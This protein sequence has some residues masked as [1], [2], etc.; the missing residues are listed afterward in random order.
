MKWVGWFKRRQWERRMDAEFRFH[1]DSQ[2]NDYINQG[3]SRE[4]AELRA[5]RE[6][7]PLD[8]AKEECRDERP[9][10]ALD[11]FLRDI[12][13]AFRSLARS[14]GFAAAVI[15]TLGLGIGA[16]TSIY[17]VVYAVLLKPL[18]YRQENKLVS[19]EVSVP[20]LGDQFPFLPPRIQDFLRW[21]EARTAFAS[22]AASVPIQRNLTGDGEPERLNGARVSA[23]FFSVLGVPVGLGRGFVPEEEQPGRDRV[24]VIGHELWSR[25]FGSDPGLLGRSIT[26]NGINHR[27][28]GVALPALPVPNL[29]SRTREQGRLDFWIPLALSEGEL[30]NRGN[31]NYGVLARLGPGA[32]PEVGRLQLEGMLRDGLRKDLPEARIEAFI[33][34]TPVREIYVGNVR[35]RL[36]L[37]LGASGTLLLIACANVANLFLARA[38]NRAGELA[39]RIALGA[40]RGRIVRQMLTESTLLAVLGGFLGIMIAL[41]GV[42]VLLAYGPGDLPALMAGTGVNWNVLCFALAVSLLT[43]AACGVFPALR[44]CRAQAG[45]T[46]RETA[47]GS[48][49]GGGAARFRRLLIGTEMAL[50]TVLL[51][52]AGLF[53]QSFVKVITTDRGYEVDGVL[54]VELPL[55][56]PGY[57]SLD[58]RIAFYREL[59]ERV[60]SIPGIV[61]AGAI[62]D[63][64][65][66]QET[67]TTTIFRKDDTNAA[68]VV[69][70]RPVAGVRC[71][72]PGYFAA[73][74][75]VLRAGRVFGQSES[76][77]VALISESLSRRLWPGEAFP[78]VIG[79]QVR[80]GDVTGPPITVLGV[81]SDFRTGALDREPLPQIYRPYNQAPRGRMTLLARTAQEPAMLAGALRNEVRQMAP[82]IPVPAVRTM[83]EI[84]SAAV[85]PRRFLMALTSLF[86]ALALTIGAVGVYGMVSYSVTCRTR[87][88]GLRIALGAIRS[89]VMRWV[90]SQGMRPVLTGLLVGLGGAVALARAL[91]S[92][93]FGITPTDPLSLC[94][95]ALILLSASGLAC[96]LPGRR[97]AALDP[98]T[99]LRHE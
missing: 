88:I 14:P 75:S 91:R 22:M 20:Q 32:D 9:L 86:A 30:R 51:V 92:Q 23:N 48:L 43:G 26:L 63:L 11:R 59:I 37:L 62:S 45:M 47:R 85:A 54:S 10:E 98:A 84:L 95:V 46:L 50:G 64:P 44:A 33:R 94:A 4:E 68:S 58:R 8:L 5:R 12:R 93:L 57:E 21:R 29:T 71:A 80:Q 7:G 52:L 25:R 70:E 79:R 69:L 90:F 17:S 89:D 72:T 19:V 49:A 56:G 39:T 83:R 2:V 66:G 77:R 6:F 38:A 18:P 87:D 24:V 60:R 34:L 76:T 78:L 96:Y 27:V 16:T 73:G 41:S 35:L 97:A 67:G 36:L 1:L 53:L 99:A 3:F 13:Y 65:S 55:S 15:L 40:G 81:V 42:P 74:G 31:W 61:A 82:D 28:I